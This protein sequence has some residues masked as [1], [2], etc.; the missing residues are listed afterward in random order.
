MDDAKTVADLPLPYVRGRSDEGRSDIVYEGRSD[1]MDD[2]VVSLEDQRCRTLW[3]QAHNHDMIRGNP[4]SR[5]RAV[6]VLEARR[7][8]RGR[9]KG[10]RVVVAWRSEL[11]LGGEGNCVSRPAYEWRGD[12]CVN[13]IHLYAVDR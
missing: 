1:I 10:S 9:V 4:K 7:R 2:E 8:G 5:N 6:E 12:S 13:E 3:T 11:G